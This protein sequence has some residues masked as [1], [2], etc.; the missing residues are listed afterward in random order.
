MPL[1]LSTKSEKSLGVVGLSSAFCF[2]S[3]TFLCSSAFCFALFCFFVVLMLFAC[4]DMELKPGPKEGAPATI[5]Q[6][7]IEI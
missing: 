7:A 2:G 6:F 1:G 5:S 4:S 3:S